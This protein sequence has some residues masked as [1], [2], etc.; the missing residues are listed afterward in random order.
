MNQ[1]QHNTIVNFIWSIADD[2]L[3]DVYTRGKYRDI[4]LPFTV[5]RRLDAILEPTKDK[6]LEMHEKLNAMKIDNQAPQLRKVSGY[7]FYNTSKYTFKKLL[8]EPGNIRQNLEIYLDGFSS[9]VQDIISKF[10]LRNQLETMEEGNITFPLIE[11]FCSST[12]N[13]SPKPITDAAG[14][15]VIEGLT[16]LGMGYVFEELIR[17]FNEENNEEAGEHFTPREIIKLMTHLIFDPIKGKIKD[18]TYLIYDPACGSGGMLTE[19]EHFALEIN[20]KATFHLYGQEV[21][22]ETFAICKADMLIKENDP[23][24]IAYGSTLSNDGFST[25]QFDFMLSNPPYGKSWKV[26]EDAIV[27]ERAK[28]G[29]AE[30]KDFR[31]KVGLPVISDGQLLFLMNMVSK[32]KTNSELGSR[33]ASVHNSS[34][35]FSGE[36]GT[37]ESEIRKYLLKNDL[38]ECVIA[39]PTDIFYNTGLPTFI[40]V[41]SNK[42]SA[43]RKGKV[44]LIN[45]NSPK[46]YSELQKS[47]GSKK[48]IMMPEH[49]NKISE[50]FLNETQDEFS[51]FFSNDEFE[52]Y[53]VPIDSPLRDEEGNII[54][55]KGKPEADK[56]LRDYEKI[57]T[58]QNI[59][60][61][62]SENIL[63]LKPDAWIDYEN[64]KLG[65]EI[66]FSRLMFVYNSTPSY[67]KLKDELILLDKEINELI[68][69]QSNFDHLIKSYPATKNANTDWIEEIPNHWKVI[70]NRELFEERIERGGAAS[71]LLSVTQDRGIIKQVDDGK[72]DNSNEDK[73][74]YK[75]V[76]IGDIVYNKMR[77][78]QGAVGH[79]AYSGIVSPAYVVL[80]PIA[81][82]NTKFFYYL[83]KTP[84]YIAQS[85]KYSY[86]L[87][88]D[89]NSLRYEDFRN[90]TSI[91]PDYDEQCEIAE[92]LEERFI[93]LDELLI[94]KAKLIETLKS[95]FLG[96]VDIRKTVEILDKR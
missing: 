69:S 61:F 43:T 59:E 13:L 82:I 64:I 30:I 29:K 47:L 66:Q 39:L 27:S 32:M 10:K 44:Q 8:N 80:K 48:N 95:A 49:I 12:I 94:K 36:A 88:D 2:V 57:P 18:G 33:V 93:K 38:I 24:K 77:M 83:F 92:T 37:G 55:K 67:S 17:K 50:Y 81:K 4:I 20:P 42:K 91:C 73:S 70:K 34:A 51:K 26:D 23:E 60:A 6:V 45:A 15:I 65:Y 46:F 86:G 56:T 5:L 90:M 84:N 71:E 63:P 14:K 62:F 1:A 22:P 79:S 9:D 53:K 7:V 54:Y 3:R 58:G 19:A 11:K 75:R 78:W 35:L 89:M 21:N 25:L 16:N 96:K 87:C 72:K 76:E 68:N 52:Y 31:F 74:K 40:I 28:K 41:L 85:R